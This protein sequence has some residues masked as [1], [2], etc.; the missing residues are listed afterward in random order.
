[1]TKGKSK[2]VKLSPVGKMLNGALKI[3][4]QNILKFIKMLLW[5]LV[6]F[7]P[8]VLLSLVAFLL[9]DIWHFTGAGLQLVLT[10]LVTLSILWLGYYGARVYLSLFLMI[11]NNFKK[12]TVIQFRETRRLVWSYIGLIF[13]MIIFLF[14]F[15]L[16][17]FAFFVSLNLLALAPLILI[18]LLLFALILLAAGFTLVIFF[19]LAVFSLAFE[20]LNSLAAIKRS[21]FLIKGYW[22][23]VCGRILFFGLVTWFFSLAIS[24]PLAVAPEDSVFYPVWNMVV[25]LI[26]ILIIPIYLLYMTGVYRELVKIKGT[27]KK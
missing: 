5:S 9:Q 16:V 13:L 27:A 24:W 4:W 3:Y 8:L 25:N 19:G 15:F 1:M 26:Q 22:W 17:A 6:G 18:M 12:K 20:N 21:I 7:I 11:K 2:S 10:I 23:A 14:P